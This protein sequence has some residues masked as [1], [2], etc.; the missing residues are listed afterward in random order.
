M[1]K[2][3]MQMCRCANALPSLRGR[4]TKQS[5]MQIS[6]YTK[7]TLKDCF[8]ALAMTLLVLLSNSLFAQ[9]FTLKGYLISSEDGEIIQLGNVLNKTTGRRAVSN[10]QG[11]FKMPATSTDTIQFSVV[12]FETFVTQVSS[13]M[14]TNTNDTIKV[15]LFSKNYQLREVTIRATNRKQ[16]SLAR[17]A[18]EFL[19]TDPLMNNYERVFKRPRGSLDVSPF[20]VGVSGG[21]TELY[22]LFSKEGKDIKH[23][24]EFYAY[25]QLQK[26]I[27]KKYNREILK[28]VSNI[29]DIYLDDLVMHCRPEKDFA[30]KAEEYEM[31]LYIKKC[32]DNFKAEKGIE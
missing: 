15:L 31:L 19:K 28:K 13:I 9:D 22:Y 26:E 23:F 1:C 20:G 3:N 29:P 18:A 30:I 14:P 16:D 5:L 25:V 24:E 21:I 10:R 6:A 7:M 8:A 2:F 4:R 12:G 17:A 11:L 27:D 32:S